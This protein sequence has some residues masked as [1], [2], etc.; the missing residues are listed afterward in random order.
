MVMIV[1][2][3]CAWASMGGRNHVRGQRRGAGQRGT[4]ER[5]SQ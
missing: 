2:L 4:L 3:I 5:G 1:A